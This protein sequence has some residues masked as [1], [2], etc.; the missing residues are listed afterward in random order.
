[1]SGSLHLWAQSVHDTKM[2]Q[3]CMPCS[4]HSGSVVDAVSRVAVQAH[5]LAPARP[6]QA[7]RRVLGDV[8]PPGE[9]RGAWLGPVRL[10]LVS[11]WDSLEQ[12]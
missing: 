8:A 10:L 9:R 7:T 6:L 2:K 3:V 5:R 4:T 11:C 1:M 12:S